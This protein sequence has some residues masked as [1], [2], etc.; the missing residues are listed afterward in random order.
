LLSSQSL[1]KAAVTGALVH[2]KSEPVGFSPAAQLPLFHSSLELP[3][4]SF[5][6]G[7]AASESICG[8][9]TEFLSSC[10]E[11]IFS[12][13]TSQFLPRML[14]VHIN[15]VIQCLLQTKILRIQISKCNPQSAGYQPL[16]HYFYGSLLHEVAVY[17]SY[18]NFL[19]DGFKSNQP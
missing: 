3:I 1:G 19:K 5:S 16:T 7:L 6:A 12:A 10:N 18:A 14:I 13:N 9:M 8:R 15:Y 11:N 17:F 4:S 2:R